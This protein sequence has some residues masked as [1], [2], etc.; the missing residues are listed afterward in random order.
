MRQ[1][2]IFDETKALER[3]SKLG[4][5]LE[6]LDKVIDWKIFRGLLDGAK[7]DK[8]Q[9]GKGGRPPYD[10]VMMFKVVVLQELHNVANDQAEYQINDRLSWKRFLGLSLSDKAPDGT[11][12]REFREMLTNSGIYDELFELFNANMESLG[13]ITHKGNLVDAS[14]VDVP[15]QRNT[16]EENK[17]IKEGGVPEAWESEENAD[18]LA[19][20]DLDAEWAKKNDELHYGYKDHVLVDTDSKMIVDYRVTGASVHDSRMLLPLVINRSIQALWADSAYMSAELTAKLLELNP[21]IKLYINE[22]GYRNNPLTDEQKLNNR[23]KSRIRAR[24]EHVFGHIT[25]SMGGLFIRCIGADRAESAIALKNLAYNISRYATLRK[26]D[27]AP[28]MA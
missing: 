21:E 9:E 14:F 28:A 8:T 16:R 13:V 7:P 27:R 24:I 10:N 18:M 11:T 1:I 3:L 6:W 19:Q 4:D 20:K 25:N 26:L 5:R 22:K 2:G 17:I 12:I 23:I 15:R